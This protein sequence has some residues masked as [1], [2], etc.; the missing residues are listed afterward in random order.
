MIMKMKK[1]SLI[2]LASVMFLASMTVSSCSSDDEDLENSL[3]RPNYPIYG[4]YI[5]NV[6]GETATVFYENWSR[7]WILLDSDGHRYYFFLSSDNVDHEYFDSLVKNKVLADG[8][9]VK[10]DGKVYNTSDGWRESISNWLDWACS[11]H[12]ALEYAGGY[13]PSKAEWLYNN[14]K[15]NA[16]V[17]MEPYTITKVE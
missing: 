17:L 8:A 15:E 4:D 12:D 16:F 10:F 14:S 1:Q 13:L 2:L 7:N 11:D 6:E 9:Q 5:R 3:P